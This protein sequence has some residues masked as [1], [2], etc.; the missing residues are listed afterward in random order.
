MTH[1][2]RNGWPAVLILAVFAV[3]HAWAHPLGPFAI[4]HYSRIQVTRV[5]VSVHYII[6]MAEVPTLEELSNA[7]RD[8]DG[9]ISDAEEQV[10]LQTKIREFARNLR[11]EVNRRALEWRV[12]SSSLTG[13]R[14]NA[15]EGSRSFPT[16]RIVTDL[17]ASIP[18][19]MHQI[20]G[21]RYKD[22]NF[23]TRAGWKEIVVNPAPDLRL[24][25]SSVPAEDLS[26]ELTRYPSDALVAP[27]QLLHAE[28]RFGSGI[29]ASGSI[30]LPAFGVSLLTTTAVLIARRKRKSKRFLSNCGSDL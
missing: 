23:P 9:K 22:D 12:D 5:G 27:P 29:D 1:R 16:I 19:D 30:Y 25:N 28:L 18:K 26:A 15:Q 21:V 24:T 6:D 8:R 14:S 2:F 3:P 11:I 4:D 10:Y 13:L 7:D 17:S 20:K